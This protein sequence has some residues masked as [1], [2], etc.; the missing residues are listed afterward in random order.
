MNIE[1]L[2]IYDKNDQIPLK[3]IINYTYKNW[4]LV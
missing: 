4:I 3:S 2:I 1:W